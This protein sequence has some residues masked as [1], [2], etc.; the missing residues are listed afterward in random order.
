MTVYANR[1]REFQTLRIMRFGYS[2]GHYEDVYRS[3]GSL[4]TICLQVFI[5]VWDKVALTVLILTQLSLDLCETRK[6]E[7]FIFLL[8][9]SA[10]LLGVLAIFFDVLIFF[11]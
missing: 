8:Q 7:T 1:L 9:R 4:N 5:F 3:I 2:S 11:E 10:I 6:A